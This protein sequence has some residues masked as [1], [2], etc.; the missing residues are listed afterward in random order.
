MLLFPILDLSSFFFF[1]NKMGLSLLFAYYL[2]KKKRGP[3]DGNP[4]VLEQE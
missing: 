2:G 1:V 3:N 4:P